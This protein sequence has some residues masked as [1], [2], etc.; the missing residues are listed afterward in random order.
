[1]HGLA[2]LAVGLGANV[3]PGQIVAITS[4]TGKEELTRVVARAAYERGARYVDVLYFDPWVKR[5]R[6]AHAPDDSLDDVPPWM[7]DRLEWLSDEHAARIT[8][9]GPASPRAL[10]GLD[11]ARAG[12]DLTPVP[13]QHRRGRQPRD[14]Q[15]VRRPRADR[16]LGASRCTPTCR[17]RRPTSG[18]GMRSSTSAGSTS[19]IPQ[20]PGSSGWT[21]LK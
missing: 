21:S 9:N 11:P 5:E 14:D 20:P 2:E 10:D 15:L 19:P 18:S 13:P 8:L 16:R 4:Y 17:R 6:I 1:M 3:Q 12:R 7:I